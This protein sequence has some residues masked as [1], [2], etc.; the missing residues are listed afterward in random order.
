MDL[1]WE[2]M[3]LALPKKELV[4]MMWRSIKEHDASHARMLDFQVEPVIAIPKPN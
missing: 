3:M 4:K 2:D 1:S